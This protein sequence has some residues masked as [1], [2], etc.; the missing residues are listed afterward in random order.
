PALW[1]YNAYPAIE[2]Q[3]KICADLRFVRHSRT[4]SDHRAQSHSIARAPTI[5]AFHR[6][7]RRAG[8]LD[9]LNV[10]ATRVQRCAGALDEPTS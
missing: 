1:Y 8:I 3:A 7:D 5:D 10:M 4:I 2:L 9:I 6:I